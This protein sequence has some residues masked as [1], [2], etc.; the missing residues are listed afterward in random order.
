MNNVFDVR[1]M[2][3]LK[4]FEIVIDVIKTVITKREKSAWF[5]QRIYKKFFDI[6]KCNVLLTIFNIYYI[7]R[8][9]RR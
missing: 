1:E 3:C 5:C 7:K 6:S 2:D 4:V 9:D 8:L